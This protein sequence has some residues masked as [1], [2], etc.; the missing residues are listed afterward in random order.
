M[1]WRA[2][3]SS[4]DVAPDLTESQ[5]RV[6]RQ[7][8]R[9]EKEIWPWWRRSSTA[10]ETSAMVSSSVTRTLCSSTPTTLSLRNDRRSLAVLTQLLR[11]PL[12]LCAQLVGLHSPAT[13][14]CSADLISTT[15]TCHRSE[16]TSCAHLR[17]FVST[18]HPWWVKTKKRDEMIFKE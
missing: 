10:T 16:H 7:E 1:Q 5:R 14:N 2:V 4:S 17:D 15:A 6:W 8:F 18:P 11:H 3:G 9:D 12:W 13:F